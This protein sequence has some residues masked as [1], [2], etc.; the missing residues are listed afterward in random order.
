MNRPSAPARHSF[1]FV[2]SRLVLGESQAAQ[3]Q[4]IKQAHTIRAPAP[5]PAPNLLPDAPLEQTAI[6]HRSCGITTPPRSSPRHSRGRGGRSPTHRAAYCKNQY[7]DVLV[8]V[9]GCG[10]FRCALSG[11]RGDRCAPWGACHGEGEGASQ[12]ARALVVSPPP[13]SVTPFF[14]RFRYRLHQSH[15]ELAGQLVRTCLAAQ[16]LRFW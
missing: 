12:S 6:G 1:R 3:F 5:V 14:S 9:H 8:P 2:L 10:R 15:Q 7:D 16:M 11:D 4:S 13:A